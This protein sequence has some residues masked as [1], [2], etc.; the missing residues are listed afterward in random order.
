LFNRIHEFS[1]ESINNSVH[2]TRD[3]EW[4]SSELRTPESNNIEKA[5]SR[6]VIIVI[7]ISFGTVIHQHVSYW[8]LC[9]NLRSYC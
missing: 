7:T 3:H 4:C 1:I 6:S 2:F 5:T 9:F 8:L